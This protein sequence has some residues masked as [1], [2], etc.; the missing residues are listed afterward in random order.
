MCVDQRTS[1]ASTRVAETSVPSSFSPVV[2]MKTAAATHSVAG[3]LLTSASTKVSQQVTTGTTSILVTSTSN[4]ASAVAMETTDA[5][6]T[7]SDGTLEVTQG[8]LQRTTS[9]TG[10]L[11]APAVRRLLISTVLESPVLMYSEI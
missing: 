3:Q 4:E 6:Q 7:I 2:S 8:E 10:N 11:S 5:R 9:T 1:S